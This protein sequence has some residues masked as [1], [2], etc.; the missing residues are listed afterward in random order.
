MVALVSGES[1]G[2]PNCLRISYATSEEILEKAMDRIA[3][4]LEKLK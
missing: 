1:F 3:I 4:A 2:A